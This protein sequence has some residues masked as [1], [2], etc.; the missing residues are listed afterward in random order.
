MSCKLSVLLAESVG[1]EQY[2]LLCGKIVNCG[3]VIP[4]SE[5]F[6]L[7]A[8]FRD[9]RGQTCYHENENREGINQDGNRRHCYVYKSIRTISRVNT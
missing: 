3:K 8:N 5:K 1:V 6:S 2:V 9:F 4:F 7:G